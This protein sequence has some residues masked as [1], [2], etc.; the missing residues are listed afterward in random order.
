MGLD[1]FLHRLCSRIVNKWWQ[2]TTLSCYK[3]S[4]KH[5]GSNVSIAR[6]AIMEG[7]SN[8]EL[9]DDVYIGPGAVIYAADAELSIGNDCLFGPGLTIMT[10][11]HRFDIV[12]KRI[13]EIT[14]KTA[15]SDKEV[16]IEEDVWCGAN[17]LI[18]KGVRIGRGSVVAAGATVLRDV[19][20]YSIYISKDKIRPRFSTEQI[21]EHERLLA[22]RQPE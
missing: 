12:G 5:C 11:D 6:G 20:P 9:G 3:K 7:I 21:A 2:L 4:M 22:L 8:M 18:L 1:A 15:D 13:R 16:I 10:G 19:P 17:V 14:E